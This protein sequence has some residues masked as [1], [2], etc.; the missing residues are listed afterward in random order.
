[1]TVCSS[2]SRTYSHVLEWRGRIYYWAEDERLEETEKEDIVSFFSEYFLPAME[3]Q[4]EIWK[5]LTQVQEEELEQLKVLL[6][7][8]R[9]MC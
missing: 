9:L 5:T 3:R 4:K 6:F 1:M 2:K 8:P 7:E